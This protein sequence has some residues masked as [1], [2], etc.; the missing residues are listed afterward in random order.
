MLENVVP[1]RLENVNEVYGYDSNLCSKLTSFSL[2]LNVVG[3]L[4]SLQIK[5]STRANLESE[6]AGD[7]TVNALNPGNGVVCG[8]RINQN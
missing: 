8:Q 1:Q 4:E 7:C 5:K 3:M 2:L 6:T